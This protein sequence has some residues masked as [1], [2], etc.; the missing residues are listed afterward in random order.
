[1]SKV[2][3]ITQV[4]ARVL[5]SDV[6]LKLIVPGAENSLKEFL[7]LFGDVLRHQYA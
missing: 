6:P 3:P 2:E 4:G 1:M 5:F 7:S